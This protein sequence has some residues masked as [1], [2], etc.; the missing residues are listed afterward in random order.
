[1]FKYQS[2]VSA[3]PSSKVTVGFQ[4]NSLLIFDEI[5]RGTATFDGMALAQAII[6]YIAS[7]IKAKTLFSTHYHEITQI[8]NQID[9]LKNIHV[10]VAH[11]GDNISFLY[12]VEEGAMGKS[13]GIN[14]ASLAHLPDDLLSRAKE[15]LN[16]LEKEE[17]VVKS[18]VYKPQQAIIPEWVKEVEKIDPLSMSP[19]EALNFL[20]DLKRKMKE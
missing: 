4:P 2:I 16:E 12:R 13:Y 20:Y 8:E 3:S 15:I 7:K 18:E 19:L 9:T 17:V 11:D 10:G 5:G 14:V 1:M 6:E